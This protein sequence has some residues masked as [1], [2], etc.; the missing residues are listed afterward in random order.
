MP[1]TYAACRH[2]FEQLRLSAPEA[3]PASLLDLGAGPGTAAWAAVENFASL[4]QFTHIERDAG[5]IA[6][7]KRLA[8]DSPLASAS[9]Q[10]ADVTALESLPAA[11]IVLISYLLGELPRPDAETLIVQAGQATKQFLVM[12]E[13]GTKRGYATI[14]EARQTLIAAGVNIAAPCP[15]QYICP[16]LPIDD[17]CHFSARVERSSLHRFAKAG[18]LGHEDEKFSYVI[19]SRDP[20]HPPE[21]RIVRH[22]HKHGGHIQFELCTA[23]GLRRDTI[24]RS[25]KDRY[26]AA[27]KAEWGDRWPD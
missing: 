15:H 1:A 3:Q 7:G 20:V 10:Q 6:L 4:K 25:Q 17:W 24:T 14:I 16:M 19:G 11:D 27:R 8:A 2:V 13:P 18:T 12:V 21:T 23:E 26:R 5:L 9:W 22:P